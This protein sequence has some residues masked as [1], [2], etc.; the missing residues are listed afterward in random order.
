M[1]N[2]KY[3]TK[4]TLLSKKEL[5]KM[6][7]EDVIS[8]MR[9]E[10]DIKPR[11]VMN[12]QPLVLAYIGDAVYEVY[13]RTMLI[14]NNRAN[15][16]IL[17]KM[18]VKYVKAQAQAVIIHRIMDTLTADEQDIVRRGRNAKSAT[19]PKHAQVTD[20][21]HSTGFEALIGYLYLINDTKR[22]IDILKLSVSEGE[23]ESTL[24]SC[25]NNTSL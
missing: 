14:T 6:M 20:Y 12:L 9:K 19:V 7:F 16:N 22:L 13:V 1:H 2:K 8:S 3:T 5:E 24:S 21:R 15:V 11:E 18:S 10:F 25:K 4:I 23:E 17:H